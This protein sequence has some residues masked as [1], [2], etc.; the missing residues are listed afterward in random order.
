MLGKYKTKPKLQK[1]L[2]KIE[3][4]LEG[5][6]AKGIKT[7]ALTTNAEGK[8]TGGTVTFTDESTLP[9]TVSQE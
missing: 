9:I 6:G 1:L 4:L 8:V 2:E 3:A 7:V 5:G